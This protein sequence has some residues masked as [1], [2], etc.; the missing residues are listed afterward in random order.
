MYNVYTMAN[1]AFC[2]EIIL[3]TVN[4]L[5]CYFTTVVLYGAVYY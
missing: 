3:L 5:L 2:G 1:T 4:M